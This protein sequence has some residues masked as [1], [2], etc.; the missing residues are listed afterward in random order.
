MIDWVFDETVGSVLA[1]GAR[2]NQLGLFRNALYIRCNDLKIIHDLANEAKH[3]ILSKPQDQVQGLDSDESTFDYTF[4]FTFDDSH[5][6]IAMD[7]GR[8]LNFQETMSQVIEFWKL[9]FVNDLGTPAL[10][11]V[12]NAT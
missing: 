4:D 9:Y 12:S 11:P 2:K 5:I 10:E 6:I 1:Q 8:R 3:A 7:D